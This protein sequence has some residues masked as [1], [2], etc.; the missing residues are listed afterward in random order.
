MIYEE[1]AGVRVL[2]NRFER[3]SPA[4]QACL[5]H[6]GT[7][8]CACRVD[9]TARYGEVAG[10]LIHV[11]HLFPLANIRSGYRLDPV[12]D[13][14]PVC[15]NCHAMIHRRNPPYEIKEFGEFLRLN[16]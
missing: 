16:C 4:R 5:Q 7:W 15:P 13:L 3:N 2:V 1:G 14:R 10:N 6:H 12:R 8:C 11:H 9:L